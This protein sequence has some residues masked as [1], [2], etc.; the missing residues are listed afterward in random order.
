VKTINIAVLLVL[1]SGCAASDGGKWK[2]GLLS[3]RISARDWGV[4]KLSEARY[5]SLGLLRALKKKPKLVVYEIARRVPRLSKPGAFRSFAP[6]LTDGAYLISRFRRGNTNS[7]GG[8]FSAFFRAPST[9]RLSLSSK[10]KGGLRLVYKNRSGGFSGAWI[11]LFD[12]MAPLSRRVYL[13][14]RKAAYLRFSIRGSRG[15]E[16]LAIKLADAGW[17]RKQDAALLGPLERFLPSPRIKRR[18]QPVLIALDKLP[19]SVDRRTLASLVLAA[20]GRSSGTVYIKDLALVETPLSALPKEAGVSA[21]AAQSRPRCSMWVWQTARIAAAQTGAAKLAAF[22]RKH[23]IGEVFLQLPYR[24]AGKGSVVE[25]R[26]QKREELRALVRRLHERGLSVQALDG[27]PQLAAAKNHGRLVAVIEAVGRY[28]QSVDKK[29]RFDGLRF[30]N[31]AYLLPGFGGANKARIV[32]EYVAHLKKARAAAKRA[33]LALALDVPFWLDSHDRFERPVAQFEGRALS[34]WVIDSSDGVAIMDYR[35]FAYGPDGVLAH[36]RSEL[37]YAARRKRRLLIGLETI[38]LPEESLM[39]F[40]T[41]TSRAATRDALVVERV[42]DRLQ[43]TLIPAE[44]RR[45]I[46]SSWR[47]SGRRL[48]ELSR[49]IEVP[50]SKQTF[51]TL[52]PEVLRTGDAPDRARAGRPPGLCWFCLALLRG[53]FCAI[54]RQAG[55]SLV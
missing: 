14:A 43:M 53:A 3:V 49:R 41:S 16:R 35:T 22:C 26:W 15:G 55:R 12:T 21:S 11:H 45:A 5:V 38:A 29:E 7:L 24:F 46:G 52:G 10:N 2:Q 1:A 40:S 39:S 9:A 13:D 51:S 17:E 23:G 28:N 42:G 32:S 37:A 4:Q 8:Y 18:F 44:K 54:D 50:S 20:R 34:E 36:A 25:F 6:K 33:R 19:R 30:D 31:E 48:L 27:D 47:G